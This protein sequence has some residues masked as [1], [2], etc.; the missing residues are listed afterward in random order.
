MLRRA[1]NFLHGFID[2][3]GGN[4]D[5]AEKTWIGVE[6]MIGEPPIHGAGYFDGVIDVA[7][8]G[9]QRGV[10]TT[11][12]GGGEVL[13]VKPFGAERTGIGARIGVDGVELA[14]G[15]LMRIVRIVVHGP[16]EKSGGRMAS[17]ST[18]PS[19]VPGV[20]EIGKQVGIV[21]PPDVHVG[22]NQC[23]KL[24]LS[25]RLGSTQISSLRIVTS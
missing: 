11:D 19:L 20:A 15:G 10:V 12:D 18:E 21:F 5:A 8:G 13:A 22:I 23:H 9:D 25:L 14:G 7:V 4:G 6:K 3:L 16:D 24:S 2:M 1:V 17:R